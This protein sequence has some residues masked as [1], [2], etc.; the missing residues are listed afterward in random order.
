[1]DEEVGRIK[2]SDSTD[3]VVKVSEYR[4]L[5]GV[6]IR[7]YVQSKKYTGFTKN[8]IRIP[9]DKWNEFADIVEKVK[10]SK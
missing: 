7:E 2:K 3:I 6:D 8:G 1:M 10:S 9:I 5:K 4:G